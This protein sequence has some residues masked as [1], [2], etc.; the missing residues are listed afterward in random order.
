[1]WGPSDFLET[2]QNKKPHTI[3]EARFNLV[4]GEDSGN[5]STVALKPGH[6]VDRRLDVRDTLGRATPLYFSID[7]NFVYRSN[8]FI[9]SPEGTLSVRL[10]EE[11][12]SYLKQ[13]SSFRDVFFLKMYIADIKKPEYYFIN[14]DR[15]VEEESNQPKVQTSQWNNKLVIEA[16]TGGDQILGR[17]LVTIADIPFVGGEELIYPI[18][19]N[20]V[21]VMFSL[22]Y[23]PVFDEEQEISTKG[24]KAG[25]NVNA[26]KSDKNNK[27]NKE[28]TLKEKL[29][30][31]IHEIEAENI[32]LGTKINKK[33]V[34]EFIK[35]INPLGFN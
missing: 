18:V 4:E 22:A 28:M 12:V 1:M 14:L 13:T 17:T 16:F 11:D 3:Y 26:A 7:L 5:F 8:R 2:N 15:T 29:A 20:E 9:E 23:Y 25:E 6:S 19:I 30:Y 35:S 21:K 24:S 34:L 27:K 32:L 31:R 10:S 33:K